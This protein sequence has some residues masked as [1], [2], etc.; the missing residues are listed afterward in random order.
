MASRSRSAAADS[1]STSTEIGASGAAPRTSRST[2]PTSA[3]DSTFGSTSVTGRAVPATASATARTSRW[4]QGVPTWLTRTASEGV[5]EAPRT[6]TTAA[7]ATSLASG[8]TASSRS[9]TTSSAAEA[10]A[11]V[12]IRGC[13][14]GTT[15]AQRGIMPSNLGAWQ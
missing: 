4:Y 5:G 9:S 6:S 11:L 12:T 13:D 10:S 15:R 7:R 3:A 14:A 2:K 1:T 8:A